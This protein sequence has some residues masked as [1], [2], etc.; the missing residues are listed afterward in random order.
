MK[1]QAFCLLARYLVNSWAPWSLL[2][3]SAQMGIGKGSFTA[4]VGKRMQKR[5]RWNKRMLSTI[6]VWVEGL[7]S[8]KIGVVTS[9]WNNLFHHL[10]PKNCHSLSH[11][12]KNHTNSLGSDFMEFQEK[13]PPTENSQPNAEGHEICRWPLGW[14][15]A[16]PKL[17]ETW[18][19]VTRR[20]SEGLIR[21]CHF[22]KWG[23]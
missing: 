6:F 17:I 8:K 12:Q 20:M 3:H 13:F 18:L 23:G 16:G 2:G 9:F 22:A 19:W 15:W 1:S 4:G 11:Q 14:G 10:P 5:L 7:F 21:K